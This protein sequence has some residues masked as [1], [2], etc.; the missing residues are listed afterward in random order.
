MAN[1]V[2]GRISTV[3][4]VNAK[5]L[6][7]GLN[8]AKGE[9]ESFATTV[10][11]RLSSAGTSAERALK[12]MY[13][14][15]QRLQRAVKAANS[16]QLNLKVQNPRA[17]LDVARATERIAKP[18]TDAQK[19]FSALSQTVRSELLPVLVSAQKQSENFFDAIARGVKVTDR[20]F[21]N[22]EARI[23]RLTQAI[24]RANEASQA[25]RSG[26]TGR[27]LA[28][29]SPRAQDEISRSSQLSQRAAEA[30]VFVRESAG[31]RQR[32]EELDKLRQRI[33]QYQASVDRR[34]TLG[35][36][37]R[38]AQSQ[39]DAL[40]GRSADARRAIERITTGSD[41][42][43]IARARAERD[44]YEESQRLQQQA[45][46]DAA[47]P[48]IA[49]ARAER[50]FYEESQ[51]LQQNAE[52][53][54]QAYIR[55]QQAA[56]DIE[57]EL[58][59]S[60]MPPTPTE[61]D[62]TARLI[63]RERAARDEER[64]QPSALTGNR[65]PRTRLI[66]QLGQ[67]TGDLRN[68]IRG[69]GETLAGD[70]GPTVDN[71][72]TRF[73]N[74]ARAGV[75]IAADRVQQLRRDIA[76]LN[77]ALDSRQ[78]TG[79]RF[80]ESFGG[81]GRAGLSLGVDER[82]LRGIGA[83]VE[84]VQGRLSALGQEVR[85]PVIAAL[86]T[87]RARAQ[88]LFEGGAI[89]TTEG[90]REL[91][92]LRE[93]LTRTLS[94]AGGGS[95]RRITEQLR[96]VGDVGRGSFGNLGLAVQ[97]A[98]FAFDDF[99]SVTGGLDQRIRAAGNNIS[100]LGFILGGTWGLGVG[101]A[102]SVGTQ[103]TLMLI[104]WYNE[105][106]KTEDRLKSLN[107][108]L[109]KQKN[110]VEQLAEAYGKVAERIREA[111]QSESRRRE[112]AIRK[113]V[114]EVRSRSREAREERILG[115][116]PEVQDARAAVAAREREL[117][118]SSTAA[119]R[120][121]AQLRLEQDRVR[122]REA[123]R[124]AIAGGG[125]PG[126]DEI[127]GA[128]RRIA[129]EAGILFSRERRDAVLRD[130]DNRLNQAGN[131][132]QRQLDVLRRARQTQASIS[133]GFVGRNIVA[134]DSEEVLVAL[135]QLIARLESS[136]Q[137]S[138]IDRAISRITE[139]ALKIAD[140]MEAA[141][142]DLQQA[143]EGGVGA[144]VIESEIIAFSE[145]LAQFVEAA[146]LAQEQGNVE[147]AAA[148]REDVA[149]IG[150]HIEALKAAAAALR[151]LT[152]SLQRAQQAVQQD[153]E[154]ARGRLDEARRRETGFSTPRTREQRDIA[155]QQFRDQQDAARQAQREI[156]RQRAQQDDEA[157]AAS[158]LLGRRDS[159]EA[160][161]AR[162]RSEESA[163]AAETA[164]RAESLRARAGRASQVDGA[165]RRIV[166]LRDANGLTGATPGDVINSAMASGLDSLVPE[167]E[168]LQS[169]VVDGLAEFGNSWDNLFGA[170]DDFDEANAAANEAADA[171]R[172]PSDRLK[173]AIAEFRAANE[174]VANSASAQFQEAVREL[175]DIE[176]QLALGFVQGSARQELLDRRDSLQQQI[177]P[178]LDRR[179]QAAAE[180]RAISERTAEIADLQNRGRE[181]LDQ[182]SGRDV[183]DTL[184]RDFEA[185][186]QEFGRLAEDTGLLDTAGIRQ[187]QQKLL[188]DK[189]RQTAPAIFGLAD[190]VANALLQGPSRAALQPTD[191][192]T[193]E[194]SRELTRLLRGDDA[195]RDQA[196]L[197]E[198][199]KEANRLL[200][201]IANAP[202]PI[203]Q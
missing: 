139:N 143:F 125:R 95:V 127:A 194:G 119:G 63:A 56:R 138:K 145:S 196:N 21:A 32:I 161:I 71:L 150:R 62:D 58:G 55:R 79:Q 12:G 88:Q 64:M 54:F 24:S 164:R 158:Q 43:L 93:E 149:Y 142:A 189:Q 98:A 129:P 81:A 38:Q 199:Q 154:S 25:A 46:T 188:D 195:A 101:I 103:F 27:E 186:R 68:R 178:E 106:R 177:Q 13:T 7:S 126:R 77:A 91:Q 45:A 50:D 181:I 104:D 111:G 133:S 122:L 47:A 176:T 94:A 57:R 96:R 76:S 162:V 116:S 42:N 48:L 20:D 31:F 132:P 26:R 49:R 15:F 105:G 23:N 74:L 22:T 123:E 183:A 11:S 102:I 157:T 121:R 184:A 151:L 174:D 89:D 114:D 19:Q 203:A 124:R 130:V 4:A 191:I 10:K 92:R 135:D 52:Q 16:Q 99:F 179:E 152:E 131:D 35:L 120:V 34:Q 182:Q 100:Q 153:V 109:E 1:K 83:Q 108:T 134:P 115:A 40:I 197:V 117:G 187:A 69:V 171:V 147:Q 33:A 61:N 70:L 78:A 97:Q 8:L 65:D 172:N 156:E 146:R 18:V 113:Q 200:D 175:N 41:D 198:L 29:V 60:I 39:L 202:V 169:Q 110:T 155:E 168:L 67:E 80:A 180:A 107:S 85:G 112:D 3:L 166:A 36:D 165:A 2:L 28:F 160:D 82:S 30:P 86:D 167:L 144:S 37:T 137:G 173:A 190:S 193:V 128:V 14:D 84:F 17:I 148:F 66:A 170:I 72:T 159:A 192:S 140:A 163:A 75:G 136:E 118:A 90:R 87:F 9:L 53:D 185:I 201:L 141:N 51:R 73:Q 5:P 44:F 59:G 6:Q